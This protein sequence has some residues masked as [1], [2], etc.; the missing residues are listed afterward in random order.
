MNANS[1]LGSPL[2][3]AETTAGTASTTAGTAS[4]STGAPPGDPLPPADDDYLLDALSMYESSPEI[5]IILGV[6]DYGLLQ[7]T[8]WNKDK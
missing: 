4:S 7:T 8:K 5:A 3:A 6:M 2:P 1:L